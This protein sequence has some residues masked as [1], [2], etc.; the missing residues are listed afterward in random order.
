[1]IAP[2]GT[3]CPD[4]SACN[5]EETCNAN[6]VCS[7]G[8]PAVLEDG[9]DCTLDLCDP[10]SGQITHPVSPA[11]G[12]W[13]ATPAAGAPS[14]RGGHTAVWDGDEM[15]VWGGEVDTA[16]DPAG[17]T[18]TGARYDPVAKKWTA[19]STAG[20]PPP[21]HSH[22][23]VWTGSKMIVWGGYG[24]TAFEST[25]GVY[26]PETDS[27]SAMSMTGAPVGRIRPSTVW[28]G[29]QMIVWG[30]LNNAALGD[31]AAYDPEAD[32]WTALPAGPSK[33]FNHGGVWT[34][35]QMIVWGGNDYFDWHLDGR[36]YDP[37]NGWGGTTTTTDAPARREGH[38]QIWTG[39][40]M[41]VWGGFDGG[42]NLSSGGLLDVSGGGGG[43]WT[44]TSSAGAPVGRQ[45]HVSVWAGSQMMVW[46]GCGD[47]S[48]TS[49]KPPFD[50][51]AFWVPGA[52]GGTWKPIESGKV[53]TGRINATGVWTGSHVI[54][55]G[56]KAGLTGKLLDTGA[57]SMP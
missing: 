2:E 14:P 34:G 10:E 11:C 20:A 46:G 12:T 9:D 31:G 30:G 22:V 21:R 27:W 38:T 33:R 55:W 39:T 57:Q 51:G 52:G 50:D 54:V 48:C 28:T 35:D 18:S 7:A 53:T 25:G 44:E 13:E 47:E 43:T 23:A 56:G 40:Q 37:A 6:G 24:D 3:P 5:G 15:I 8:T 4:A 45:K 32:T 17:V 29:S 42:V 26:D 36:F 41:I 19:M 1:E 16:V 49:P